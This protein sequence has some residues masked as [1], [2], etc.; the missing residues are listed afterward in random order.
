[1]TEIEEELPICVNPPHP[2]EILREEY[3]DPL[4]ITACR[5][6]KDTGMTQT[7]VSGILAGKRAITVDTALRLGRYFG[8]SP[9]FW[10]NLQPDYE[11]DL[12]RQEHGE[13]IAGIVPF[14]RVDAAA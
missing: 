5:L 7:R 10:L 11:T 12:V 14:R 4:C 3:L 13:Q 2:G 6:A 8:T 1:V 9:R